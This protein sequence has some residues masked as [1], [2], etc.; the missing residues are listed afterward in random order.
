MERGTRRADARPTATSSV[1]RR[2][3]SLTFKFMA[4]GEPTGWTA[5]PQTRRI[6]TL[7]Q[8]S[9]RFGSCNFEPALYA[10]LILAQLRTMVPALPLEIWEQIITHEEYSN[11]TLA[12]LC[13][14]N[15]Q[16]GMLARA[17]LYLDVVVKYPR[18]FFYS[19]NPTSAQQLVDALLN[20]CGTDFFPSPALLVRNLCTSWKDPLPRDEYVRPYELPQANLVDQLVRGCENVRRLEL[21]YCSPSLLRC[22]CAMRHL[23]LHHLQ[24]HWTSEAWLLL[25]Q[26]PSLKSLVIEPDSSQ[27]S[28]DKLDKIGPLPL[29]L[30]TLQLAGYRMDVTR[31]QFRLLTEASTSTLRFLRLALPTS[32]DPGVSDFLWSFSHLVG[33]THLWLDCEHWMLSKGEE[34]GHDFGEYGAKLITAITSCPGISRLTLSM[35]EEQYYYEI[36]EVIWS[37]LNHLDELTLPPRL[38][39]LDLSPLHVWLPLIQGRMSLSA[40]PTLR[41]LGFAMRLKRGIVW[42]QKMLAH[43]FLDWCDEHGYISVDFDDSYNYI[44]YAQELCE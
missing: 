40:Y 20:G 18:D 27:P 22:L 6:P 2:L 44:I 14:V 12:R 21:W 34:D 10:S 38:E 11:A 8:S 3:Q 24:V 35:Y 19:D 37:V 33:L 30:E 4:N 7:V 43:S 9:P 39:R 17:A 23:H 31:S 41:S 32:D 16:I 29:R 36:E 25:Q 1:K 13:L 26:Q 5:A 28:W 15:R 42:Q